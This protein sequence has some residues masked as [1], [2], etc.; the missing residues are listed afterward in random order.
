M[1]VWVAHP[2]MALIVHLHL[3]CHDAVD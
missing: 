2:Y 3:L 1:V